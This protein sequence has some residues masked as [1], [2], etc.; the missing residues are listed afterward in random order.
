MKICVVGLGAIGG[1]LASCLVKGG[2]E[3]SALC[4]GKT[5]DSVRRQGIRVE[6][7]G[8]T[9]A[10]RLHAE[11]DARRLGPQDYVLIAMKA[12]QAWQAAET[13]LPLL[14]PHTR[15]VVIQNG[16]PWWYFHDHEGPLK[17]ATLDSVDPGGRQKSVFGAGRALGCVAYATASQPE[18][19]LVRLMNAGRFRFGDPSSA[20]DERLAP[21]LRVLGAGGLE[22][23]HVKDIRHVVW[24]KLLGNLSINPVSVLTEMTMDVISTHPGLR[25][26]CLMMM[27]EAIGVAGQVGVAIDEVPESRL[28][29]SAT[30]G[31]HRTS[32]LQDFDARRPLEL[33]CLVAAVS[34][35]ARRLG[36]ETPT[37]DT[38]LTLVAQRGRSAGIYPVF[39]EAA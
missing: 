33:D 25:R 38:V 21:L 4:R 26:I 12:H 31:A 7:A 17:D 16:I 6:Q 27:R 5:L 20:S 37:I 10:S 11:D 13:L 29:H 22:C 28:D 1:Y 39:P 15:V 2:G 14:G 3:V 8:A 36:V 32:M 24:H 18:P 34:E 9:T 30:L 35:I 19:G 23:S